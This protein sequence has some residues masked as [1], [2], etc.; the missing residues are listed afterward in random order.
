MVDAID[1]TAAQFLL[2]MDNVN[3]RLAQAQRRISSG[4]SIETASD[5]PDRID[6]LL[7]LRSNLAQNDQIKSNLASYQMEEDVALNAL[8][9]ASSVLDNVKSLAGPGVNGVLTPQM[10]ATMVQEVESYMQDIVGVA[11]TQVNGRYIFSGDNDT[12][13]AYA[14]DLTQANGVSSY[15]GSTSTRTAQHPDGATF[16]ISKTAD[17]LFDSPGQSVFQSLSNLRTALL[18]ND[19][20]AIQ[21]ALVSMQ[22]AQD[23][24]QSAESFYGTAQSRINQATDYATNKDNQLKDQLSAIQDAD[25]TASIL[26]LQDAEFQRQA[27]LSARSK[28]PQTSLFDYLKG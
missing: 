9:Q 18:A 7:H 17:E 2:A 12:T 24:V 22:S 19:P 26:E 16:A 6:D 11:N 1:S 10:Q 21:K 3:Q 4:K 15:A 23:H 27:S 25:V 5:A 14:F 28:V 13:P 8:E 20:A